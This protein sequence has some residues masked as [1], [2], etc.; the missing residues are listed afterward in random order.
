MQSWEKETQSSVMAGGGEKCIQCEAGTNVLSHGSINVFENKAEP[1]P[2]DFPCV[3]G[4]WMSPPAEHNARHKCVGCDC[5]RL[6][7]LAK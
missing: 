1:K 5:I 4:V 3:S 7:L 2:R 6:L